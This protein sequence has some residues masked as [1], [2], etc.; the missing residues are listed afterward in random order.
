[1]KTE[2]IPIDE[3]TPDPANARR[4]GE[5]NLEA[6]IDS[7]KAFGQQKPIVVDRRGIVV[8]GNGTLEAAKRL[9][10]TEISVV[11][12]DLDPTQSTAF[13]IADNRTAELADWDDEVLRSLLD[14]MDEG[15]RG[16][17]AFNQKEIDALIESGETKEVDPE[18]FQFAHK[19]PK[20]GFEFDD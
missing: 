12:S 10:W 9:G 3:P 17:L 14:S 20:C 13:G 6:I 7:L 15:L 19:C 1:M 2:T 18:S 5:R 11:R 16:V 4:H 8:A